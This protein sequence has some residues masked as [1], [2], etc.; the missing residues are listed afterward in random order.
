MKTHS[1]GAGEFLNSV[2]LSVSN[3]GLVFTARS[4]EVMTLE[5]PLA[6]AVAGARPLAWRIET[7]ARWLSCAPASG[8]GNAT[9]AVLAHPGGL[10]PGSYSGRIAIYCP[11]AANSPLFVSVTLKLHERESRIRLDSWSKS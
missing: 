6:I 7:N 1:L 4:G 5:K 3:S 8:S 2:R 10:E 9:V 11:G